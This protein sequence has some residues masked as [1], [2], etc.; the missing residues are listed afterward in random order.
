MRGIE[1]WRERALAQANHIQQTNDN[2]SRELM[3]LEP[4]AERGLNSQWIEERHTRERLR[5]TQKRKRFGYLVLF[6]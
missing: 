5:A 6:S 2:K 4:V 3:V 1:Q